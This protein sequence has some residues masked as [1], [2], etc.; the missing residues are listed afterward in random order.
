MARP[1]RSGSTFTWSLV[2]VNKP[3]LATFGGN[4]SA[5]RTNARQSVFFR[6]N[7]C[8]KRKP[9]QTYS[10]CILVYSGPVAPLI[11]G[12]I[13]NDTVFLRSVMSSS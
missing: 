7:L 8:P 9:S 1:K 10:S 6:W 13:S 5:E 11:V 4:N 2:L 3:C 12:R